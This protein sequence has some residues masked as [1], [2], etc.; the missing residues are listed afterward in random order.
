MADY[1]NGK[2]Y[3]ITNNVNNDI[4]IGSTINTLKRRFICHKSKYKQ[5]LKGN[6]SNVSVFKL[7][8]KYG[9]E[10]C[11][12]ELIQ[13]YPC[14]SKKQ[15]E[16]L[17]GKY[18]K[19]NNEYCINH[20]IAGRTDKQYRIDNVD[21]IKEQKKQYR[22]DNVDK[23]KEQKKQYRTDNVDK[24]KQYRTDNKDKIN[25]KIICECGAKHNK[26]NKGEHQKTNKHLK[27]LEQQTI[28]NITNL[29]INNY[30]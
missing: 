1:S 7:F 29:T 15:L 26:K 28:I 10:N 23:I 13:L 12:I 3:K 19:D 11:A 18:M 21:K 4:Y 6:S 20:C 8:D 27:Y 24:I 16:I 14:E 30:N 5:F 22:I 9:I 2:I 17:E 25:E